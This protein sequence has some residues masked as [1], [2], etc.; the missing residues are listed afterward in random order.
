MTKLALHPPAAEPFHLGNVSR[1]SVF[2]LCDTD[3]TAAGEGLKGFGYLVSTL[4]V[5]LLGAGAF[6]SA[7]E[8]PLLLLCLVAGIVTAIVGMWL[9]YFSYKR[10]EHEQK[11]A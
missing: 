1:H 2:G 6:R 3:M 4:S 9:R 10:D 5:L 8:E 7:S 11:R